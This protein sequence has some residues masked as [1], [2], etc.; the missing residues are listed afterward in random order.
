MT[1]IAIC[2]IAAPLGVWIVHSVWKD[3]TVTRPVERLL[4]E[5]SRLAADGFLDEAAARFSDALEFDQHSAESRIRLLLCDFRRGRMSRMSLD[6]ELRTA[7]GESEL[8]AGFPELVR[9]ELAVLDGDLEGARRHFEKALARCGPRL[10]FDVVH[11]V[12][13]LKEWA[14]TER[15]CLSARFPS[16]EETRKALTRLTFRPAAP[17]WL[18]LFLCA[19]ASEPR[20][21]FPRD[22]PGDDVLH[23]AGTELLVEFFR[24]SGE[25]IFLP[26]SPDAFLCALATPDRPDRGRVKAVI[27]EVLRSGGGGTE[28]AAA[29]E[30]KFGRHRALF[31][32]PEK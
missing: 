21:V 32:A 5:G 2:I 19:P 9:A 11:R 27:E 12:D 22:L 14:S 29:L 23:P 4:V 28:A 16:V 20:L 31:L 13:H 26:G 25:W 6:G 1:L 8:P 3:V 18:T 7:L 15:F 24:D 30:E 10:R 17:A